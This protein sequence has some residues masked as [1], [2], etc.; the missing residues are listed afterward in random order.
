MPD[1]LSPQVW[2]KA[3]IDE[4]GLVLDNDQY[5]NIFDVI[6]FFLLASRAQKVCCRSASPPL[7]GRRQLPHRRL[8]ILLCDWRIQYLPMRPPPD[9]T[10]RTAPRQ[11]WQFASTALPRPELAH[12]RSSHCEQSRVFTC[13]FVTVQSNAS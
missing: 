12:E 3:E 11:M 8:S 6:A 9:V 5:A 7:Q 4:V 2:A 1:L 13:P 10:A